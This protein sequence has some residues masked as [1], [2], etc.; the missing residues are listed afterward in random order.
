MEV[1][2]PPPP[3]PPTYYKLGTEEY[4]YLLNFDYM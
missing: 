4:V 1:D 3:P 2:P